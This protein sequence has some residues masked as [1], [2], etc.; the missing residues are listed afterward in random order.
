MQSKLETL[1]ASTQ[2]LLKNLSVLHEGGNLVVISHVSRSETV[3][4]AKAAMDELVAAGLAEEKEH[5][6][7]KFKPEL[8]V[9]LQQTVSK[10]QQ[11]VSF[12]HWLAAMDQLLGFLYQQC[13]E[14]KKMAI[15]LATEERTNLMA[16]A[17]EMGR[18]DNVSTVNAEGV[19]E[20]LGRWITLLE[21]QECPIELAQVKQWRGAAEEKLGPW[22]PERFAAQSE[23]IESMLQQNLV[24]AAFSA[25]KS[26]LEIAED[27]GVNAY[28]GAINDVAFANI[29]VARALKVGGK[30]E[31]ALSYLQDAQKLTEPTAK[32]DSAAGLYMVA[33][34]M[35]QGECLFAQQQLVPAEVVYSQAIEL[36]DEIG[37][38]QGSGIAQ[39]QRASLYSLL[40]RPADALR[41]Y[42]SALEVFQ[43]LGDKTLIVN[44]WHQIA[45]LHR[46]SEDFESAAAALEVALSVL[47]EEGNAVGAITTSLELGG[48]SEEMNSPEKAVMHYQQALD[49]AAEINDD[50]RQVVAGNRLADGLRQAGKL[51][52]ALAELEKAVVL[53]RQFGHSAEPWKTWD[54]LS[55]IEKGNNNPKGILSAR[56][57]SIEAYISY[58]VEGGENEEA[59]AKLCEMVVQA[60]RTNRIDD[61]KELM[62]KL[63]AN[64]QWQTDYNKALLGVLGQFLDGARGLPLLENMDLHYR[65]VAELMLIQDQLPEAKKA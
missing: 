26:L 50:Y 38:K 32:V 9:H 13:F 47:Q 10:E 14:D 44:V 58:R 27:V 53:G 60:V 39:T 55:D 62:S 54:I 22:G 21:P 4:V 36:A 40:E 12:Q 57:K 11:Q 64:P 1:S 33:S 2:T 30:G 49:M 43:Q 5:T 65:H 24:T 34:L 61:A 8:L 3:E 56:L 41:G 37:D 20:L 29:L 51:K 42:E 35:E 7:Y 18:T 25:A 63:S 31:L 23:N 28:N 59:D 17:A 45:M 15:G 16:Y 6:F 46:V 19:V 48:L 52:E